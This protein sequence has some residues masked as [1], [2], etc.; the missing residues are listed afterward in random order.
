M[1][2][3]LWCFRLKIKAAKFRTIDTCLVIILLRVQHHQHYKISAVIAFADKHYMLH[4][5]GLL[6]QMELLTRCC[7]KRC[8]R[9]V[10]RFLPLSP[11]MLMF[12]IFNYLFLVPDIF[13]PASNRIDDAHALTAILSRTSFASVSICFL[14]EKHAWQQAASSSHFPDPAG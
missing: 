9:W 6:A 5:G 1:L 8:S 14:I 11:C 3:F 13:Y 10:S 7:I 12:C 2:I 4:V